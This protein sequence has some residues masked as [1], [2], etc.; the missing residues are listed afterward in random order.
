NAYV[1][2]VVDSYL[3]RLEGGLAT[4]GFGGRFLI[5]S[6]SGG[7]LASTIARQFPI[8][9]LESG[10]AAG[11]LM[12]S[13]IGNALDEANVLSFDMGGTT[14]KGGMVR[15]GRPIKR[16]EMEVAR[17]HEFK[18]GSGLPAKIPVIDMIE[19]GAGGGSLAEIDERGALRMGPRSA[20]AEPGPA[21]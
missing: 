15:G 21:C 4:Q 9:L 12:S 19:I 7:T 13:R 1:Q 8:R 16:Y 6:S 20:G 17:V 14:A 5:M 11:A 18:A 3:E 2:P 10:P